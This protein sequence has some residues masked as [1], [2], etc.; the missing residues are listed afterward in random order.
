MILD[1]LIGFP[2]EKLRKDLLLMVLRP[3]E[4]SVGL[5]VYLLNFCNNYEVTCM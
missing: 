1:L 4:I 5:H 2:E 3:A